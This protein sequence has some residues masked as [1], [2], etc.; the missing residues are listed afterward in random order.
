MIDD[1]VAAI[2]DL[3]PEFQDRYLELV[4]SADDDPGAAAV[5]ADLGEFTAA[6]LAEIERSR[7]ALERC[8]AAVEQVADTSDDAEELVVWSFLESFSPDDVRLLRRWLGPRTRA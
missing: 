8:L 4:A 2:L 6:L 7:P 3:V 1:E 5:M